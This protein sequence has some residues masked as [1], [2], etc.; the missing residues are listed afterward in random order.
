MKKVIYIYTLVFIIILSSIVIANEYRLHIDDRLVISVWGHQDLQTEAIVGPDGTLNL[1]LV[2]SFKAEGL[3]LSELKEIVTTKYA[4]YLKN[5]Q[6]NI[7]LK[8]YKRA[9]IMVLGEVIKP[10][11]Y[12]LEPGSRILDA[13]SLAGGFNK[14]ALLD[15]IKLTRGE[16]VTILNLEAVQTGKKMVEDILLEDGD[17]LYIPETLIEVNMVGEVKRPGR[18]E[19]QRGVKLTDL[20]AEAGGLTMTAAVAGEYTSDT[21]KELINIEDLLAG[22]IENP[23]LK[24]GDML[25][26]PESLLEVN[27]VGEV[28][29][30]GRYQLKQGTKL[31]D[32]LAQAGGLNPT[33]GLI[34]EYTTGDTKHELNLQEIIA[35]RLNAPLLKDGDMLYIPENRAEITINGEVQKPGTYPWEEGLTLSAL[36]ARAGNRTQTGNLEKVRLIHADNTELIINLA[37][38]I[39]EGKSGNNPVLQ[40]GDS[41]FIP[42]KN[43]E[44]TVLGEVNHPGAYDWKPELKLSGLLARAGNPTERGNIDNITL[45][46]QDGTIEKVNFTDT[47]PVLKPGDTVTINEVSSIDWQ[48]V[49]TYIAGFKLIKDFLEIDW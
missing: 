1:P 13:I 24:D 7:A 35:G 38:Y 36:L 49:F 32:L 8:E 29:K 48:K 28:Q 42:E 41:V 6:V 2:G 17:V 18:Y 12:Q 34:G 3:A 23:L 9:S 22:R 31:T 46:R 19:F 43:F 40:P 25:F 16:E 14:N 10:G 15:E 5:P 4:E 30:P 47:D 45:S 11:T 33:A 44:V 27:I 39:N 20:L 37:G 21:E 26:I